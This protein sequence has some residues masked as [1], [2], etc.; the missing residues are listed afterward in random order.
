M[1]KEI[2]E[3]R[4]PKVWDAGQHDLNVILHVHH[5]YYERKEW[6]LAKW[7]RP[8]VWTQEQSIRLIESV[9]LGLNIG[10]YSINE[11]KND[12]LDF[13]IIDGQQ[14]I[15]SLKKYWDNEFS[16]YGY[17]W[18]DLNRLE[19]RRF[20]LSQFS[21]YTTKS[22]DEQYLRDYYQRMNFGGTPHEEL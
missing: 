7:Q 17:Y 3:D 9:W 18:D 13:I 12:D 15:I 21:K 14:R 8:F 5:Y 20:K 4:L 6:K 16:V 22:D 11:S 2:L 1:D 10:T 19:K